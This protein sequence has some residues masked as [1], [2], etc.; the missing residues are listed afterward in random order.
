MGV[1]LQD[2]SSRGANCQGPWHLQRDCAKL[3]ASGEWDC[4]DVLN[5]TIFALARGEGQVKGF[6]K[7]SARAKGSSPKS[8]G[9]GGAGFDGNC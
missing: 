7:G 3:A 1:V 9:Y 2:A 6:S 5:G 8:A 4:V